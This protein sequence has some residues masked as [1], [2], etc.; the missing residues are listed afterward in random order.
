[1]EFYFNTIIER[2][3]LIFYYYFVVTCK[4]I[5][6]LTGTFECPE[7]LSSEL[8]RWKEKPGINSFFGNI[9]PVNND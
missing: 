1:M 8:L 3:T 5:L 7:G 2:A 4:L 6:T 9:S